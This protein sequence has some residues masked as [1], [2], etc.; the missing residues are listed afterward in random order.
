MHLKHPCALHSAWAATDQYLFVASDTPHQ[1]ALGIR[2][3]QYAHAV[4]AYDWVVA[5]GACSLILKAYHYRTRL[6]SMALEILMCTS[7]TRHMH[8]GLTT[9][10]ACMPNGFCPLLFPLCI[11]SILN[12]RYITIPTSLLGLE[13]SFSPSKS[14]DH[15]TILKVREWQILRW[16]VVLWL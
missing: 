11:A 2:S 8:A 10:N 16:Q 6:S 4:S 12:H 13:L 14:L 1:L 7:H 5:C 9:L 3:L 15:V